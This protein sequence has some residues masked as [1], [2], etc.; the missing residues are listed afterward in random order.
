MFTTDF[1][2]FVQQHAETDVLKL[3]LQAHLYPTIN[4][5]LAIQQIQGR[6]K[7]KLKLPTF[8]AKQNVIYP[9]GLSIEQC[10]S[11]LTAAFKANLFRD[12][13]NNNKLTDKLEVEKTKLLIDLTGGFGIDSYFFSQV[14]ENVIYVEQ[15]EYLAEIAQ[16]NFKELQAN[17]ITSYK[18]NSISFL[19]NL[20]KDNDTNNNTNKEEICIYLDPARRDKNQ[21]KVVSLTDCEPNIIEI[22]PLLWQ[23]TNAILLKTSPMLDIKKAVLELNCAVEVIIVAVENECKEVLYYLTPNSAKLIRLHCFNL[24]PTKE[25]Q[26]FSFTENDEQNAVVNYEKPL[27]F[28][29]EPNV[30]VLKSGG[31]KIISK[32]FHI[33]KLHKNSHLYTSEKFVE[34]FVGRSFEIIQV[35][36]FDK[37]E[38]LKFLPHGKANIVARNFPLTVE[39]FRKKTGIKDGGEMYLFATTD[40]ENNKI[41]IITKQITNN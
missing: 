21:Q 29:Y 3:A 12:F 5:K 8:Y 1:L 40:Y 35:C 30:A 38:I 36:K 9:L 17:N 32:K 31:F 13:I 19:Q 28:L 34:R 2:N 18:Q 23:K 33:S 15:Q 7:A 26:Q 41:V 10:S 39:E 14:F 24:H 4:I 6:Q 20:D 22:L 25:I 16:H 37:K 11:E 27:Q